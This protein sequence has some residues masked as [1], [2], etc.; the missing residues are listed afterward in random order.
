MIYLGTAIGILI[1]LILLAHVAKKREKIRFLALEKELF[2]KYRED[3]HR[4][5][6]GSDLEHLPTA[7]KKYLHK[8]G[9][10]GKRPSCLVSIRQKGR[11]RLYPNKKWM[12]FE[13]MEV[14]DFQAKMYYWQTWMRPN[15]FLWVSGTDT[16]DKSKGS[17]SIYLFSLIRMVRGEGPEID[18]GSRVRFF[19][20]L[21]WLPFAYLDPSIR[22]KEVSELI[23]EGSINLGKHK[24]D[25]RFV[26]D[27]TYDLINFHARRIMTK[28]DKTDLEQWST[29]LHKFKLFSGI[30][31]PSSGTGIWALEDGEI[32]PYVDLEITE[33]RFN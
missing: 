33:A 3:I 17:M 6:R 16:F 11:F 15:P 21:M 20:E 30:R 23:V 8:G 19:N 14:I 18:Q 13:A 29:P 28:K 1:L 12:P 9:I 22:W 31:L 4:E 32:Y 5:I 24:V 26:F 25:A 10:V 2:E 27:S 7:L